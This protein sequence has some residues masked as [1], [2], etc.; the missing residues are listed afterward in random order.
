[1][2]TTHEKTVPCSLVDCASCRSK[3]SREEMKKLIE[4]RALE[5]EKT[6]LI[7]GTTKVTSFEFT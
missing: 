4:M 3:L 7:E 5:L 1:M 2:Q 6:A